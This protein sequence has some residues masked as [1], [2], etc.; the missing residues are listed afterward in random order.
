M[1]SDFTFGRGV[2][3][4]LNGARILAN[5]VDASLI[6]WAIRISSARFAAAS[7]VW[8]TV[9][10]HWA[11]ADWLMSNSCTIGISSARQSI[12]SANGCA[13]P[14]STR[15]SFFAFTVGLTAKRHASHFRIAVKAGLT[16][17]NGPMIDDI[18][19]RV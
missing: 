15:M 6:R 16:N 10:S 18:A 12:R 3:W 8:I 11:G 1:A 5:L 2:A 4:V 13:F 7:Q 19:T 14:V 9:Q 17:A